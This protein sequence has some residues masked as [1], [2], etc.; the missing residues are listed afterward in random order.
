MNPLPLSRIDRVALAGVEILL[1]DFDDTLTTD[2]KLPALAY[3]RLEDLRDTGLLVIPVTGRPAGWCDLIARCWPVAGVVGENGALAFRYDGDRMLRIYDG[4]ES[5]LAANRARLQAIA[6]EILGEVPLSAIS[7]D[8][9]FRLSDLA[10]DFAEDV[11]R[12]PDEDVQRIVSIFHRHGATAKVSSIH[13]NGWFGAH[14][15]LSMS[16]RFLREYFGRGLDHACAFIGD[17]PND[18]PMF[19]EIALGVGV[20][21]ISVF[22]DQMRQKPQY[23]TAGAGSAGFV[24]FAD[25]LLAARA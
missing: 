5:T 23:L 21:N 19:G 4:G 8:Q 7:A 10:I 13:V 18:E 24:E 22:L 25:A 9:L 11:D 14:D 15:K 3:S 12:L 20:A 16:K 1:T 17:S 2:G 6:T